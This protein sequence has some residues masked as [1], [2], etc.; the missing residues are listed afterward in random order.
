MRHPLSRFKLNGTWVSFKGLLTPVNVI[1][2]LV[3]ICLV[4]TFWNTYQTSVI[5]AQNKQ[6]LCSL[7]V[8]R[9]HD[10]EE[11][12]KFLADHPESEIRL[13]DVTLSRAT[14]EDDLAD[15]RETVKATDHLDCPEA[16]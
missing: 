14:I 2:L 10:V 7:R 5:T 11:T 9:Q 12:E 13:G 4:V 8:E 1:G 15:A 16:P 6:A 3:M